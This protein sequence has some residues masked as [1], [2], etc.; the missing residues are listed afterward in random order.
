MGFGIFEPG[1]KNYTLHRRVVTGTALAM[2]AGAT[3]TA[4]SGGVWAYNR[5][6]SSNSA[7]EKRAE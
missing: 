4:F 2:L 3:F 7:A 1:S 5:W 6:G